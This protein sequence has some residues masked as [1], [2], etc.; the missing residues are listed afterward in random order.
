MERTNQEWDMADLA[1]SFQETALSEIFEKVKLALDD[2]ED[3]RDFVVGGGVSANSRLR[4]KVEELRHQYPEIR[5]TV[6][7]MSCCTDNATMIAVA[8]QIAYEAGRRASDD[9]SADAG[10]EIC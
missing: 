8:G 10:M 7:P 3:I 5:F 4:E 6:P 2:H 1:A 9:L